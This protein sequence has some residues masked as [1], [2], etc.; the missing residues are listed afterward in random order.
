M[1]ARE[2]QKMAD[3]GRRKRDDALA[4]ALAAGQ[5]LRD[6]AAAAGVGERTACRRWA[7][8]AFRWRVGELRADMV[9]R[10]TGMMGDGMAEAA[11]VL[12]ALLKAKSE[13]VRLGACQAMLELG[14]KLRESVEL[15]ER[16]T[17]LEARIA[18]G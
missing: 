8:P 16:L 6:G 12:R 17:A 1:S 5:T 9:S 3:F 13:S 2:W 14:V 11:D 7:D 10:A 18:K 4:V 15:E